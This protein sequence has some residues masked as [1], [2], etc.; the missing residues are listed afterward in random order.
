MKYLRIFEKFESK[1]LSKIL[2]YIKK[3][4]GKTKFINDIKTICNDIDYPLSDISDSVF[5]Y[6]KF[7]DAYNLKNTSKNN[8]IKFWFNI[9]GDYLGISK[10]EPNSQTEIDLSKYT[11]DKSKNFKNCLSDLEH[12]QKI[13]IDLANRGVL[14]LATLWDNG[15]PSGD[16]TMVYHNFYAINNT[17]SCSGFEPSGRDWLVHGRYSWELINGE[18]GDVYKISPKQDDVNVEDDDRDPEKFNTPVD[19]KFRRLGHEYGIKSMVKNADFALILDLNLLK[20]EK[21][22]SIKK[23]QREIQKKDALSIKKNEDIKKENFDRYL[24]KLSRY[25]LELGLDQV[26]KIVPRIFGWNHP[27]Y[28]IWWGI[29]RNQLDEII[30]D[31]YLLIET[32]SESN[33][34]LKRISNRLKTSYQQSSTS[35]N[36]IKKN[37]KECRKRSISDGRDDILIFLDKYDKLNN[38]ISTYLQKGDVSTIIDLELISY[39]VDLIKNILKSSR[40]DQKIRYFI[41]YVGAETRSDY[42]YT[43]LESISQDTKSLKYMND[44]IKA[45]SNL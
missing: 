9:D 12:L 6:M 26:K 37:I 18:F 25:D 5:T 21:K 10:F 8:F 38:A 17:P 4:P 3:G 33:F 43:Y 44:C 28:F 15:R 23:S 22:P 35:T 11:I 30:S 20:T 39:K 40:Q 42:T 36:T 29:N 19:N 13:A 16:G 27:L 32:P 45:I 31:I 1:N 2:N 34:Y 7:M 41:D 14:V 24:S